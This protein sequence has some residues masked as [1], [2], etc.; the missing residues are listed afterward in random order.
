MSEP[1]IE[2][3]SG[4]KKFE[5]SIW[6]VCGIVALIIAVL[7]ILKETFNVLLLVL[8]GVLIAIY[9]HGVSRWINKK[10]KISLR[11]SMAIS[12]AVTTIV[13]F[14]LIYFSSARIQVQVAELSDTLP[15]A[16]QNLKATL[17]QSYVGE[18]ILHTFTGT[19]SAAKTEAFFETF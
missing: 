5:R 8:A 3:K 9:F 19:D 1:T 13:L 7:W 16:I 4:E 18:R 17:N 14:L 6:K 10:T 11:G 12:V 2:N 15:N